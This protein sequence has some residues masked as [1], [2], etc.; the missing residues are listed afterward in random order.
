MTAAAARER[1]LDAENGTK[2]PF[3]MLRQ[4]LNLNVQ[5]TLAKEAL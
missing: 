4:R 5:Q 3:S 1:A 2:V